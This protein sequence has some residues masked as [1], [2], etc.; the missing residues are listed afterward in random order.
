VS[1][2]PQFRITINDDEIGPVLRG[3]VTSVRLEDGV[4]SML[5]DQ[6][7][8]AN[9]GDRL[10]IEFAN[11]GLSLL[12]SHIRGLGFRPFPTGIKAASVRVADAGAGHAFDLDNTVRLDL[13][14]GSEGLTHVFSGEVTGVEASFP[15]SGTPTMT[16]IAHDYLHR[17][18]EGQ[19]A[20]G[21]G[22]LP[23]WLIAAVLSA[24][25]LLV[26]FIDPVVGAE[27]TAVTILNDVFKGSGRKQKGQSDYEV[28]K[29]IAD[30]Y[31]ADF[32]VE[33]QVLFLSRVLG[34]DYTPRL[35]LTWGESLLSFTPRVT[36]VGQVVG[37]AIKFTVSFIPLD[38][39]VTVTWDFDREAVRVRIVPGAV[40][41]AAPSLG[42]A[43]LTI[44]K[45]VVHGPA[46][47]STAVLMALRMLRNRIN[48]RLTGSGSAPGDPRIRAGAVIRLDGLGPSFSGDYRVSSASHVVD[49]GGYRTDFKVRRELIP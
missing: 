35:T 34:K 12:Q 10:E 44:I 9:I 36:H 46:D 39:V 40:A 16:L 49:S 18:A 42:G 32:W 20:R 7:D 37:V 38:F 2:V 45:H 24:E 5:G 8:P 13:G 19:Y 14:Y 41:A 43:V 27:S 11:P 29:E 17:L 3:C 4:P 31:D 25:N 15:A 6:T 33:D 30:L 23:D 47:I 1:Y 21:F 28:L 22:L 48:T 26:P